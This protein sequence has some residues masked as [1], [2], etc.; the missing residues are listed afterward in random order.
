MEDLRPGRHG[1]GDLLQ[2]RLQIP[3]LRL[4]FWT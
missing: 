2:L 4:I 1:L 3:D